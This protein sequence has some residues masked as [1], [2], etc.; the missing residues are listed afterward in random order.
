[1]LGILIIPINRRNRYCSR[2]NSLPAIAPWTA[3]SSYIKYRKQVATKN[4]AN[5]NLREKNQRSSV[6][7]FVFSAKGLQ[8]LQGFFIILYSHLFF[9]STLTGGS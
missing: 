6:F 2:C 7:L 3:K 4:N 8:H 5:G 9:L 1:M